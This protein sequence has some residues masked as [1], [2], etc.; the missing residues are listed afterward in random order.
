MT[1]TAAVPA[2]DVDLFT[3]AAL[4]SPHPHYAELR[5]LGPVVRLDRLDVLALPR[6]AEVRQV[7]RDPETFG[8][9]H[10]IFLN[11]TRNARGTSSIIT[12]D[13]PIHMKLRRTLMKPFR[14]SSLE[15]ISEQIHDEAERLVSGLV[16]A[17]GFDAVTQFAQHLPLTVV[18]KLVGLAED[19]RER[20]LDWASASFD[21]AGPRSDEH[22]ASLRPIEAEMRDWVGTY[23]RPPHLVPGGWAQGLFD[24]EERGE[25]PDGWAAR[26]AIDYVVPSLDTTINATSGLIWLLGNHPDQWELLRSHPELIPN[27]IDE[28]IRLESPVSWFTRY[29]NQD[30]ELGGVAIPEGSRVLVLYPSANRD[31]L[32]WGESADEFDITR[33]NAGEHLG[34]GTGEHTCAGQAL[35][36]L[37]ITALLEA[38]VRHVERI[39]VDEPTRI[40]NQSLYGIAKLPARFAPAG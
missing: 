6:Y 38:M 31:E 32:H 21:G 9:G 15:G 27:A 23:A 20:M 16:R 2:S 12:S 1:N 30:T 19:G 13:P 29:V 4:A 34:F 17:E 10:G 14:H 3:D 7:L 40:L 8:S 39:E 24:A 18:S 11:E 25:L 33:P 37:E 35:A 22:T 36:K 26:L 28:A 5:A